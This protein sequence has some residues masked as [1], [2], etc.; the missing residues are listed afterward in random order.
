[1]SKSRA[2]IQQAWLP[3]GTLA[4]H[5]PQAVREPLTRLG[6]SVI[7]AQAMSDGRVSA[8]RARSRPASRRCA[9]RH[10]AARAV[11][12]IDDQGSSGPELPGRRTRDPA[13]AGSFGDQR[14]ADAAPPQTQQHVLGRDIDREDRVAASSRSRR[15]SA[16]RLRRH[17]CPQGGAD[18]ALQ[19]EEPRP[20]TVVGHVCGRR[21]RRAF[22]GAARVLS[23]RVRAAGS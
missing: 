9:C 6:S 14:E 2:A 1:M 17:L 22:Y 23:S 7:A 5:G 3:A 4:T 18:S 20:V 12:R 8:L 10:Q 11:D 13:L 15:L 16:H 19:L 21:G